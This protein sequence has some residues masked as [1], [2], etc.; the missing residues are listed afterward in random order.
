LSDSEA[1]DMGHRVCEQHK[2]GVTFEALQAQ[3]V[4][5]L[6]PRR[7]TRDNAE[8]FIPTALAALCPD[9]Y[10]KE[11]HRILDG[12]LTVVPVPSS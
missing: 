10:Q 12:H 5:V 7:Y 3:A 11:L 4:R 9:E 8:Q 1:V 6:T 2:Q